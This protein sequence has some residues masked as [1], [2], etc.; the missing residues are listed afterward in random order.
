MRSV[1]KLDYDILAKFLLVYGYT[2]VHV[3]VKRLLMRKKCEIDFLNNL[4]LRLQ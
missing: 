2:V 4:Y 1:E 3:E